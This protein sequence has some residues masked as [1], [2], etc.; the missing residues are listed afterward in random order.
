MFENLLN[1]K[2]E[3]NMKWLITG[4]CGFLGTSLI[5]KL[6]ESENHSIRV[7]DN[8]SVGSRDDLTQVCKFNEMSQN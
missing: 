2:A 1:K 5:K 7:L 6:L 8:L 3:A 4:G